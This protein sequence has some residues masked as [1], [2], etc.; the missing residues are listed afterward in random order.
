MEAPEVNKNL[1]LVNGGE[2]VNAEM[3]DLWYSSSLELGAIEGRKMPEYT[4]FGGYLYPHVHTNHRVYIPSW[5]GFNTRCVGYI[6][7]IYTL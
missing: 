6:Y 4:R 3:L 1:A 5:S 2:E 7:P